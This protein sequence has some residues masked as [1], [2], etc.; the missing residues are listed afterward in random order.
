MLRPFWSRRILAS[1]VGLLAGG[2]DANRW[3]AM[4]PREN[5]SD[6]SVTLRES[7]RDSG[8]MYTR[9]WDSTRSS[10]FVTRPEVEAASRMPTCQLKTW[11][12][13]VGAAAS[14]TRMLC[15]PSER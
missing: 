1:S 7:D 5:T 8:D 9:A 13:G 14:V 6:A 2:R 15:G 11:S 4:A 12:L 10:T 3:K